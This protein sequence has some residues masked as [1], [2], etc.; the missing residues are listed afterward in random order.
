M[1]IHEAYIDIFVIC[2]NKLKQLE[3]DPCGYTLSK[4]FGCTTSKSTRV[5][6]TSYNRKEEVLVNSKIICIYLFQPA[7]AVEK[8]PVKG[9]KYQE[10]TWITAAAT[11]KTVA[12][13]MSL[14]AV[15]LSFSFIQP[16]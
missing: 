3:D 10:K 6:K 1:N 11:L 12:F 5:D 16:E 15:S 7:D 2:N 4:P 9:K 8:L 14:V 13:E